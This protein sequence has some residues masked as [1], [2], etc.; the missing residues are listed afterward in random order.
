MWTSLKRNSVLRC[1]E[2]AENFFT[3][4]VTIN[5]LWRAVHYGA[6]QSAFRSEGEMCGLHSPVPEGP[7]ADYREDDAH[8][9]AQKEEINCK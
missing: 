5:C 9:L 2:K 1:H 8:I 6:I 4:R 3:T 7:M